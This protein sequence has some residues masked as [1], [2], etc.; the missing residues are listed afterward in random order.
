MASPNRRLVRL[1]IGTVLER[2]IEEA[3]GNNEEVERAEIKVHIIQ[4]PESPQKDFPE[5]RLAAAAPIA[6]SSCFG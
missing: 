4:Q 3:K 1:R 6:T 2:Q 5:G